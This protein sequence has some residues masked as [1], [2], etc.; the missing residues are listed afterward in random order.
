MSN[1]TTIEGSRVGSKNYVCENFAYLRKH[2]SKE[3]SYLVCIK[4]TCKARANIKRGTLSVTVGHNHGEAED[5]IKVKEMKSR[6]K[7][8]AAQNY[9]PVSK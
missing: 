5:E 7:K 8:E 2:K 4:K 3:V 1:Y 9:I 6:L